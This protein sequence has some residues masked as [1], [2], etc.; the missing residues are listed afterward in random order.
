[1]NHTN[2]THGLCAG[3]K[4]LPDETQA[5]SHTQA[6]WRFLANPRVSPKDLSVPLLKAA[7]QAV[8]EEAGEWLLCVHDWSRLNYLHHETKSDRLQMTHRLDLGY[9]LQSS[10][11][12]SA[13]DG[14]PLAVPAQNL[15]TA[16]GVWQSREEELGPDAQT[17]L[18]E[19]TQRIGWLEQQHFG[20]RLVHLVDREADSVAHLRQWSRQGQHWLVRV[21]GGSSVRY[22][23]ASMSI[24]TVAERLPFGR[25]GQLQC[26]GRP[27]VHSLASAPVVLTRKAKPTKRAPNG[28]RVAPLA[29]EPLAAR[30]VVSRLYDA[31]ENLIAEWFLLSSLP[32][33]VS[34]AQIALWYYFRWQI[35]SFFKLLKQAGH[36]LEQWEQ[37]SGR[38][39]FKRLLIA[40]HA[41]LLVWRL[42]R[43]SGQAAERTQRFL[44]RLSGRQM[45]A[46]RPVTMPALLDG[47]FKL[48]AMLETLEHYSLPELQAF[49]NSVLRWPQQHG[50]GHV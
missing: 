1:M 12:V 46:S 9:E 2:C 45:K 16:Q 50:G 40:T 21:K 6:M 39:I 26:K 4:A 18:D 24:K 23:K 43:Q 29:G 47:V 48:F 7:H 5:F 11:L 14:A 49:A 25:V 30:L 20:K 28:Q 38:A 17:H 27:A 36:Q 32:E 34:D 41:C 44:I 31:Q 33:S 8:A 10:L 15:V 37:E 3:A 22:E 19:L 35:E 13:E 42:A